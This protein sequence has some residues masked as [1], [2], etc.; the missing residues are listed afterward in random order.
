M[1]LI[2][3]YFISAMFI[4]MLILYIM[5]PNPDVIVKHPSPEE[6][7]SEVYVD[8]KGVCYRYHRREVDIKNQ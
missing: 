7:V 6:E 8:D 5:Y 2:P 1:Q 3:I 4:T